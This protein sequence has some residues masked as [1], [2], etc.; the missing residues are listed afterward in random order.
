M[1][2]KYDNKPQVIVQLEQNIPSEY[3][4][5]QLVL[6][7]ILLESDCI[8]RIVADLSPNLFHYPDNNEV[9]L[10]ILS[11]YKASKPID[12]MTV[13]MYLKQKGVLDQIGG[14]F[15]VSSLTNRV[16]S[17]A[18]IDTHVKILQQKSLERNMVQICNKALVNVLNYRDDIFEVY[19]ETQ[20]ELDNA[21]KDVLHYE[22]K[23]I[24]EIHYEILSRNINVLE[25]GIKSGV[26]SGFRLLD[27]VTNGW[28]P[29]D[30]I[31]LAGRPS[32]GK[33]AAAI[34]MIIHPAIE[35]KKP[36]AIFSLE[37]SN[38][39]I[40]SRIQSYIS[41]VNVSKIVKGQVNMD[42]IRQIT[43]TCVSLE[44]SPLFIDDTPNISLIELKSKA[45]KLVKDKGV[46]L[47]VIDYLQL[48]RS[49][50]DVQ[51]R[52]QEIAEISKGLKSLA[53]ELNIPVIALSQLSRGVESRSDKKPMLSD[54]RESGQ[55]EQDA[56]MVIFCFRPEYYGIDTYE[57]GTEVFQSFGLMMLIIA[58]HRNGELGEI[59][60]KFVHEQAKIENMYIHNNNNTNNFDNSNNSNTFV[61]T[62]S[63]V[64]LLDNNDFLNQ[65]NDETAF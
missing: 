34:S 53:K 2:K 49:G 55:I 51:N 15:Y 54:L 1:G 29:S 63:G 17:S 50:M 6:G 48:M 36:V 47:I 45:R 20:V 44:K 59:P 39:Q 41:G 26:P 31:I 42:E 18:N 43:S 27:N 10:A 46:Q 14:A 52:E 61:P 60:L 8:N 19:S 11:L 57:I 33:T 21:L 58:K 4:L 38:F 62:S 65:K 25:K 24:N 9:I 3:E 5:E 16:A 12:I 28:Q 13:C 22:L 23:N 30:L 40:G 56:D 37:M 7:S 64:K 32:M 35:E